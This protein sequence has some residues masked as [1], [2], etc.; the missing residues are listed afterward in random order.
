MKRFIHCFDLVLVFS[1]MNFQ[2]GIAAFLLY[3]LDLED[4]PP[5]RCISL[6][7]DFETVCLRREVLETAIV[8]LSQARG[9]RA[10]REL[11][12]MYVPH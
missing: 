4:N 9:I 6:H 2:L 7:P 12:N 10:P 8:G 1:L 5:I 11:A 3:D